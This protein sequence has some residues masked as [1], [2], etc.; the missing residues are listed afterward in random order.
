[1]FPLFVLL[2]IEIGWMGW[3]DGFVMKDGSECLN[4][5]TS[6]SSFTCFIASLL[7]CFNKHPNQSTYYKINNSSSNS[8]L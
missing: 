6:Q 4:N 3:M 5:P 2:T 1:M 7:H 8:L